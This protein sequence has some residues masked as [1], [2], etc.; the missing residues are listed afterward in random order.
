MYIFDASPWIHIFKSYYPKRF[1]SLWNILATSISHTKVLSTDEV[2]TEL[3]TGKNSPHVLNWL[4]DNKNIFLPPTAEETK[5]IQH[6]L[7][8]AKKGHFK[9]LVPK[10]IILKGGNCADPFVIAK[11]K[12]DNKCVVTQER[13]KPNAAKIPNAC[14]HFGIDYCDLETFMERENWEF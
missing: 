1:P 7:Y 5:F 6:D 8:T 13:Y 3:Q 10:D 2:L 12:I 11:A 14:E 4:D 9:I